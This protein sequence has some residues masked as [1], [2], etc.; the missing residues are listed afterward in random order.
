M[1]RQLLQRT[2]EIAADYLASL[3]DRPVRADASLEELRSALR[4]RLDD[5]PRPALEVIEEHHR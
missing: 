3:P 4:V 2:A 5:A 1:D